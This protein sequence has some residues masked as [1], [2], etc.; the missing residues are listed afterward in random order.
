M[1]IQPYRGKW[2]RIAADAFI[3]PT[4]VVAGDVTVES[5]ASIWFGAVVRGDEAPVVIGRGSNVQDN[6]VI[7]IDTDTP[8]V[9]GA[10]CTLGH[11]A[12]V[13]GARLGDCVLVGMRATVLSHATVDEESII[14]AGAVVPE[15]R[16]IPAGMLVIGVPG[17]PTR[18]TTAAERERIREGAEH[19]QRYAREYAEALRQMEGQ[20]EVVP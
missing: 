6:C 3:A 15:G 9:I 13:H 16:H 1:P 7:H 10:E 19:Y 5:G 2:P 8:C 11:G 12:I 20:R 14:A 17:K 18:P 4:A